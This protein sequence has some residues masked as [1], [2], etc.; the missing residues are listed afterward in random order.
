M[1]SIF[2][3]I[4]PTEKGIEL[5]WWNFLFKKMKA[6]SG[7]ETRMDFTVG[8]TDA[9]SNI[10]MICKTIDPECCSVIENRKGLLFPSFKLHISSK[11][12]DVAV[13]KKF[14]G[15]SSHESVFNYEVTIWVDSPSQEV[16]KLFQKSY[17]EVGPKPLK[18][19]VVLLSTSML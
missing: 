8:L 15:G 13:E 10:L 11:K 2:W 9:I 18:E 5:S 12:F 1:N 19:N 7:F 14:A 3:V 4:K 17:N 6:A 16:I